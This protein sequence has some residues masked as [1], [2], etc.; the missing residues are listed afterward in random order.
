M[1]SKRGHWPALEALSGGAVMAEWALEL[2]DEFECARSF[3]RSS[4]INADTYP[5]TNRFACECRH[6]VEPLRRG[7]WVAVCDC[8]GCEPIRL[9]ER[10]VALFEPDVAR[11]AE[12][13]L[14]LCGWDVQVVTTTVRGVWQ[15]GTLGEERTPV[16]WWAGKSEDH[17]R[18]A[19]DE[20]V[21]GGTM[22]FAVLTPTRA[23]LSLRIEALLKREGC[24]AVVLADLVALGDGGVL[25][26]KGS[27]DAVR[28]ELELRATVQ[29]DTGEMLRTLHRKIDAAASTQ[30]ASGGRSS[31][32]VF[33]KAG[34]SWKVIFDGR[35]ELHV[36]DTL[37]ALY[38]DYLLHRPN[39]SF[40]AYDV[41]VAIR[42]EKA[43]A[44]TKTSI[45]T[46]LDA[47]A[48]KDYLRQL[49]KLRARREKATDD[50]DQAEVD[51]LD[52]EMG[53]IEAEL[54]KNGQA[55]DAGERARGNVSKAIAAV[56]QRLL[57]GDKYEREFGEHVEQFVDTG[58]ECIY[59]QPLGRIWQ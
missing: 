17:L 53:T 57:K 43:K 15:A 4:G 1:K 35:P 59:N 56:R 18:R 24:V 5:C 12:A 7:G 52:G 37:G 54:K 32:F 26:L 20:L 23:H 14:I 2:G 51:R 45:Q 41:E 30:A 58:Y 36:A 22:P 39:E 9:S 55:S 13:V 16:F 33:Q 29:R 42:P 11:L 21:N 40:P 47:D 31:R 48:V 6:R 19:V 49:N 8:G 10:E 34:R 50:G 46:N 38:L 28:R 25:T 27:P 3:L 44:R